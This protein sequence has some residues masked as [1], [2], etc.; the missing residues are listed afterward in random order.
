MLKL[1]PT[2][3][4]NLKNI[5]RDFLENVKGI[6]HDVKPIDRPLSRAN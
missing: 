6:P 1:Y 3:I 2:I 5:L 4:P